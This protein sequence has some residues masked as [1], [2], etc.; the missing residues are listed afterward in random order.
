[1]ILRPLPSFILCIALG[2][3]G[4]RGTSAV[5]DR[6]DPLPDAGATPDAGSSVPSS[7]DGWWRGSV[8]YEIFVRSFAD[9]NG[10]GR[11]DF[12]G[13][14]AR[15]DV[16]ND[17]NPNTT[18]DLG[19]DAVW[20]MPIFAS[21]SYHGYDVTDYRAINPDY[22]TLSDFDA[23]VEAAHA[24]G[25]RVVLD[26]VLNHSSIQHPRFV[27]ARQGT[28]EDV[29]SWYRW[30]TTNPGWSQ[31]WGS[32]PVWHAANGRF[33]YG[34][35]WSGMPDWN[36]ANPV[37]EAE[38][39]DAMR[40]W[41]ARG[42]DGFRID[43]ARHLFESETGQLSD[44]A[45]THAFAKRMR[46]AL[47]KDYPNALLIAEAWTSVDTVADYYGDDDEFQLAFGF[48]TSSAIKTSAKDGLRADFDQ[49]AARAAGSYSDWNFEAPFLANHDMPRVMRELDGDHG[50]MRISAAALMAMPGTPFVYYGEEI[51]MRGGATSRDEDKRTPMR[52]TDEPGFGFTSGTPWHDVPELPGVSLAAQRAQNGSLWTLFRD[53][54]AVRRASPALRDGGATQP[55]LSGGGRGTT[56]ILRETGSSRVLFVANFATEP[57]GAFEV[58]VGGQPSVLFQEGLTAP[59]QAQASRIAFEG[60]QAR[61]FAFIQLD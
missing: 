58:N 37:V 53:L 19:I 59:P 12:P 13:L 1:M 26:F 54:I 27:A 45:E 42:V 21:P 44:V 23:F 55:S 43:A 35:F 4:P 30:R 33:Y 56:R 36:L 9:S 52:W 10:D 51:G 41:L 5:A 3:C 14:T 61:G 32:G 29:T 15:L 47:S 25:I 20:L 40:F 2:A 17:G 18:T 46:A 49:P 6:N 24:R 34:I 48:D 38:L 39:L 8:F 16:L 50:A 11:G 60:L 22:G 28:T 7:R 31:P 57:S